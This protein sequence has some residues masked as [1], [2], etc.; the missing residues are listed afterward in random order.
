MKEG[1]SA[2][3]NITNPETQGYPYIESIKSFANVCDEVI[4]VDGGT[5]DGS[6]EKI[7]KIPRIK[8]IKGEKWERNFS[9]EII[10]KNKNIGFENCQYKF[11]F[12]FDADY[13]FHERYKEK[14]RQEVSVIRKDQLAIFIGKLNV[15]TRKRAFPKRN[16]PVL[17]NK[18]CS[19][20]LGYGRSKKTFKKNTTFL[21]PILIEGE[22]S[23]GYY[24]SSINNNSIFVINSKMKL[25]CYD[26]TF[27]TKEQ[28]KEQ[29]ERFDNA[30]QGYKNKKLYTKEKAFELFIQLMKSRK[31]NSIF[32]DEH[33]IYIQDKLNKITP[34][35]WGYN[36]WGMI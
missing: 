27:M 14:L 18:E 5:T 33:S 35:M 32:F 16:I 8:I 25:Y 23:M 36:N 3:I 10:G 2:H 29:R 20:K 22:D 31:K 19:D 4:V 21:D 7:K 34:E 13:I 11:A 30:L 26:F 9:W 15:L 12:A 6:L 24:G 28:I 1:I 17:V